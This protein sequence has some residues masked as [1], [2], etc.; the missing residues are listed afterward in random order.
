MDIPNKKLT[1]RQLMDFLKKNNIRPIY[2]NF[3][4]FHEPKFILPISQQKKQ[5]HE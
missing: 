3:T 2:G 5:K 4:Y 1:S